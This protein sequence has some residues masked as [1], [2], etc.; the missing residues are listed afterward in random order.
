MYESGLI[1]LDRDPDNNIT[2]RDCSLLAMM[3]EA[4]NELHGCPCF[5]WSV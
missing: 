1:D 3:C 4:S 5:G 2:A